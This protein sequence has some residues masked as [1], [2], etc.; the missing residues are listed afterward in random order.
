MRWCTQVSCQAG[1]LPVVVKDRLDH[2]S[3]PLARGASHASQ[4]A[5]AAARSC[6]VHA[7][8]SWTIEAAGGGSQVMHGACTLQLD[9]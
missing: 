5:V 8:F 1:G 9:H 7:L 3:L 6:M 2:V 4:T